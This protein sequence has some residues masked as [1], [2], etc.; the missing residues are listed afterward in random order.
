VNTAGRGGN[1]KLDVE[2]AAEQLG[3][4]IVEAHLVP[5]DLVHGRLHL[6]APKIS[7]RSWGAS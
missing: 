5:G 1:L 4:Q 6:R 2:H 3:G 7:A